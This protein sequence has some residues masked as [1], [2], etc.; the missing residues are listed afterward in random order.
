MEEGFITVIVTASTDLV[1]RDLPGS[2]LVLSVIGNIALVWLLIRC[3]R[4]SHYHEKN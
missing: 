1:T 3:Y 2:L 4:R